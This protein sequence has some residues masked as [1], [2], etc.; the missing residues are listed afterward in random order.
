[1]LSRPDF[2]AFR[3]GGPG[4]GNLLFPVGRAL[5]GASRTGGVFVQPTLRQ[6]KI[7]PL[8]R[9]EPDKRTYG[10]VLHHRSLEDWKQ[11]IATFGK[12]AV[13]ETQVFKKST[14]GCVVE[15]SGLKDYFHSLNDHRDL[16]TDYLNQRARMDGAIEQTFDIAVHV[17]LGDFIKAEG[18]NSPSVR[19][20]TDWYFAAIKEAQK[21]LGVHEPRIVVFT[22]G[23]P[24]EVEI[25]T[26]EWRAQIDRGKNAVTSMMNMAKA[27]CVVT[28]RSTFSMWGTF[29][30][31]SPAIWEKEFALAPYWPTRPALDQFL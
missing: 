3:L 28:S 25:F 5:V 22:D 29:L 27:R 19:S 8:L 1:M 7:G 2:L 9:F 16:M 4:L 14:A 20:T 11:R 15:Y 12:P 24:H 26:K 21:L 31:N 18:S 23:M 30:G 6:V 10:N 17:R 13:D